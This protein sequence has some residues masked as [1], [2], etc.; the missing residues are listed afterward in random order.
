MELLLIA[1]ALAMGSIALSIS[2]GAKYPNFK[3]AQIARVAFFYAA[4]QFIMPLAG[5][6]LGINF[7]KFIAQIDHFVAFGILSFLGVKMI[8]E[9]RR[10]QD[11]PALRLST[12][13]LV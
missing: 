6:A 8:A 1:F 12:K 2:N 10:E 13:E 7:V 4:A 9:S 11:E 5:Y 3:F